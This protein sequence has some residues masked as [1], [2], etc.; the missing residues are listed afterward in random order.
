MR[1]R[2]VEARL[3]R[4]V[5]AAGGIAVKLSKLPGWPD[6]LVLL[7]EARVYFIEVKRPKGG[8]LALHQRAAHAL[9]RKLGFGVFV[10]SN[11]AEVD[12]WLSRY[13]N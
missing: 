9:I 5:Q 6:R 4:G 13:A 11:P 10:L 12:E 1:E 8:R 3:R 2:A 7:P